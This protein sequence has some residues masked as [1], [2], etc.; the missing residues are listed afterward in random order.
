MPHM[1]EFTDAIKAGDAARVTAMLDAD[2][3]LLQSSEH[4]VTPVMLAIYHGKRE[5][6]QRFADRGAPISFPEACAL[7]DHNRAQ[8]MLGEDPSLLDAR[9]ADGFPPVGLAIF[10]GHGALARW[11]IEQGADVNAAAENAQRVAPLHAAA[12]VCDRETLAMLL[13]RGADVHAKQQQDFTPLHGAASRGDVAIAELL[14]AHGADRDARS[15]DGMTPADVA[16]KYGHPAFADW[17]TRG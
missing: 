1:S 7:G 2:A 11:L 16:R 4:G 6:A 5:L 3:S 14:L 8:R 12:A 9:S 13:A 17:I 15:A 10:F